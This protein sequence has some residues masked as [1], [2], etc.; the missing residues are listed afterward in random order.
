MGKELHNLVPD[1]SLRMKRIQE[2]PFKVVEENLNIDDR[3]E[4]MGT[5]KVYENMGGSV[6]LFLEPA[7]MDNLCL[8]AEAELKNLSGNKLTVGK[9]FREYGYDE[10]WYALVDQLFHFADFYGFSIEV[11]D[12]GKKR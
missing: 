6:Y 2:Y 3:L 9:T 12:L 5:L 1:E 10:T 7:F 11:L 4:A 8:I